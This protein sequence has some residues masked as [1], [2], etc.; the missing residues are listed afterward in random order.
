M[1]ITTNRITPCLWFDTEAEEAARYYVGVFRNSRILN[2]AKYG[3]AGQDVT[4]AKP[5]S[6]MTVTFEL[7][8]HRFLALNGG[9][10][11]KF[12]EA[13]SF[14]INCDTQEQIDYYWERLGAGGD[15]KAQVCGWLKDKFGLSWQVT[16]RIMEDWFRSDQTP[17]AE[18]AMQAMLKMK[19]LDIEELRRAYAGEPAGAVR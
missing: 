19:K 7:E 3:E 16:P 13:V 10:A 9:P 17:A 11:F 5:G 8:G 1:P 15:P 18:R 2:V 6:V 14:Q 4:G 12:N